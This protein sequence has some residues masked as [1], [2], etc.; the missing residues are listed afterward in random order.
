MKRYSPI[1]DN[2]KHKAVPAAWNILTGQEEGNGR[3]LTLIG[4]S[5]QGIRHEERNSHDRDHEQGKIPREISCARMNG[6]VVT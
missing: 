1:H 2:S 6:S 3:Q 4:S 5:Y